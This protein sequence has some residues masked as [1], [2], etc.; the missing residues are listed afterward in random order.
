MDGVYFTKLGGV[1]FVL[2]EP[3]RFFVAG[4]ALRYKKFANG[5]YFT[6]IL[7]LDSYANYM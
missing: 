7:L 6:F 5:N 4:L 2:Y 3:G 1:I